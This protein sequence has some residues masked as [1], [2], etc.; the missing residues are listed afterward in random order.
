MTNHDISRHFSLLANLTEVHGGNSFKAKSY[1]NTAFAI[2]RLQQEIAE[3]PEEELYQTFG[4]G[5]SAAEKIRELLQT[6]HMESLTELLAATPAGILE[7][8]RIKGLGPKKIA[9]IWKELGVETIGELEYA[10][11]ENRLSSLK[12][13]GQKTQ[14]TLCRQL[15]FYRQHEG[16]HLWSV[17]APLAQTLLLQLQKLFPNNR[18]ALTG[19]LRRQMEIVSFIEVLCDLEQ[20]DLLRLYE[21]L[22][23]VSFETMPVSQL[24]V[25]I[26]AQPS[27]RFHFCSGKNFYQQ[28]FL[29]TGSEEFIAAFLKQYILPDEAAGEAE[30]CSENDLEFIE[31]ALRETEGILSKAAAGQLPLLI[32][33]KDIRGIIHSHSTYSDGKH[34]LAEMAQGA[35]DQGFE[36]LVISDHSQAAQYAGGLWPDQ[37]KAQHEEIDVLNV[38]LAPFKIFKSIEADILGDGS[39]D[40]DAR[41]LKSMDLVIASV[42][43]NLTMNLEKAMDRVLS[44]VRNPFTTI[45]GHMTGRLLLSREGYPLD[46]KKVIDACAAYDVA[47]EVNANPRRL[48]MDWR[49]IEYALTQG[50]LLSINPDAHSISGFGDIYYGV[51]IG[52]KGG[53]TAKQNL[54][55]FSLAEFE[56]FLQKNK[57]KRERRSS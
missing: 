44:A 20:D 29:T 9:V 49:W 7:M 18:F 5:Q 36:Y 21:N 55:S 27:L 1:A 32:R 46:H 14:E 19:A 15:A 8:M 26:P 23:G 52:Q 3:M 43:S 22:E 17:I 42:H 51:L 40:Y 57:A 30:I 53:L 25:H 56:A 11:N 50:V 37:I 31:P 39:L 34:P 35:R 54:S 45:L 6:G 48:D 41:V 16:M 4:I 47:I 24:T 10:C 13:F 28:L 38:K 33:Q 12:G 2:D